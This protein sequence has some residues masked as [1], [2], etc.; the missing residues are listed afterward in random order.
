MKAS[1]HNIGDDNF[2]TE[3]LESPY[4][5][6]VDFWA[7]W[8]APCKMIEPQLQELANEYEAHLRIMK[9][10]IDHHP[11]IAQQFNIQGIPC[12]LL[13]QDGQV[14]GTRLGALNKAQL[15]AFIEETL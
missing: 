11:D 14:Q 8:C 2:E 7:E 6:L 12:L 10:N 4:T 13:F 15:K 3:V 9:V 1:I 5:I